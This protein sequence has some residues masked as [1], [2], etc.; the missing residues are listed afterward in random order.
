V[1]LIRGRAI[2]GPLAVVAL[3]KII[4]LFTALWAGVLVGLAS[5]A[6]VHLGADAGPSLLML[7]VCFAV[8]GR[9]WCALSPH[10]TDFVRQTFW[11]S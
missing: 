6:E 1:L 4:T 3:V 5:D 9:W 7:A 8:V 10:P 2:A 11:D